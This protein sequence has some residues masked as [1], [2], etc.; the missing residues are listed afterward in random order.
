[1]LELKRRKGVNISCISLVASNL[2]KSR[3]LVVVGPDVIFQIFGFLAIKQGAAQE[4]LT[5]PRSLA[6]H[7]VL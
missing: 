4:M 6:L 2:L 7:T 5:D 1:M 3:T